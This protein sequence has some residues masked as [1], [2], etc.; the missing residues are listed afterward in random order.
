MSGLG[1][2]IA[3]VLLHRRS[4]SLIAWFIALGVLLYLG[5]VLWFG[6]E[7]VLSSLLNLGLD[8]LLIGGILASSAYAWRFGRWEWALRCLNNSVP[9]F[10]HFFIYL[11]GLALTST[12]GKLGETFRSALLVHQGVRLNHSLAAF[13]A[14]RGSDVIGMI[15]LGGLASF[16]AQHKYT[17]VWLLVLSLVS[18]GSY[19]LARSIS[20]SRYIYWANLVNS[21]KCIPVKEG[22]LMLQA[23]AT[24]WT[25]PRLIVFSS[26]AVAA[27]GT[28]ALVFSWFCQI[29]GTGISSAECILIFVKATLFGAATLMPG[30]LGTMEA[31]IIFQLMDYGVNSPTA[32]TLAI[33]IRLV[34]LWLG[35]LLGVISLLSLQ[36]PKTGAGE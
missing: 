6:W 5:S 27:Y 4:T 18:A 21:W 14:D 16:A 8:V 19:V 13:L 12:P 11:S 15:L 10:T 9:R 20:S 30:G 25:L 7:D 35:M 29:L 28:Q 17:W 3:V 32:L 26:V 2:R 23:W 34:T 31:A 1:S 33:S 24:I 36:Y 22:Q